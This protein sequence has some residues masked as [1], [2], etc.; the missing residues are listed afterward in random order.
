MRIIAEGMKH[1]EKISVEVTGHGK[2]KKFLFNGKPNKYEIQILNILLH[3]RPVCCGT[4]IADYDYDDTNIY[5]ILEN[6]Y[7]DDKP[8]IQ[9]E[10]LEPIPY[11]KGR[12]Y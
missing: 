4:Y 7:F 10:D 2:N 5:N 8:D 6:Y 12:V 3:E 9:A 11:A 1:G